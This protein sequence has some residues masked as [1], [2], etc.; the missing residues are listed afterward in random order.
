M[1]RIL[2]TLLILFATV[3]IANA[4]VMTDVIIKLKSGIELRGDIMEEVPGESITVR[5]PEGDL[6]YYS[7]DEV[8]SIKDPN[9]ASKK[10]AEEQR[11]KQEKINARLQAKEDRRN[12]REELSLGN[13]VGYK[14]ILDFSGGCLFYDYNEGIYLGA[15][16]INGVNLG[17][18]FSIGI[19]VG[20]DYRSRYYYGDSWDHDIYEYTDLNV[21]VFLNLRIPFAKNRRV[22]PYLAANVGYSFNVWSGYQLDE[23]KNNVCGGHSYIYFEPSFGLDFRIKRHSSFFIAISSPLNFCHKDN[24]LQQSAV[25]AKLGF[26]F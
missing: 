23:N 22:S 25:G 12:K 15:S 7:F 5:T 3:S 21:P 6:F 20:I 18:H 17:A 8:A 13:Y 2:F 1:K 9:S 24:K 14:G 19:G 26:T 10:R 11:L 4:Q 16:F